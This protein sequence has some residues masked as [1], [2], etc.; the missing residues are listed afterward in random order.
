M[1]TV[2]HGG[3]S[4][5]TRLTSVQKTPDESRRSW[6]WSC[7]RNLNSRLSYTSPWPEKARTA[8]FSGASSPLTRSRKAA[9]A[10]LILLSVAFSST[11]GRIEGIDASEQRPGHPLELRRQRL[12]VLAARL[13][14]RHAGLVPVLADADGHEM[15]VDV[16]RV[17]PVEKFHLIRPARRVGDHHDHLLVLRTLE[18]KRRGAQ[19]SFWTA[20]HDG[21]ATVFASVFR[22]AGRRIW[23]PP[24][25]SSCTTEARPAPA[26]SGRAVS[27]PAAS[28]DSSPQAPPKAAE[29][30]PTCPGS[31][32]EVPPVRAGVGPGERRVAP[33]SAAGWRGRPELPE[34]RGPP[35]PC[36]YHGPPPDGCRR[37]PGSAQ[38]Q[39]R[40]TGP[41]SGWGSAGTR[42]VCP[43][44]ATTA[45]TSSSVSWCSAFGGRTRVWAWRRPVV[46]RIR[47]SS[48][49]PEPCS[50]SSSTRRPGTSRPAS[51]CRSGPPDRLRNH[52]SFSPQR[53]T[54]KW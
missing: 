25:V 34:R 29:R 43:H 9:A 11:R 53:T 15:Q 14:R 40:G 27:T 13:D 48:I 21:M 39:V 20:T 37:V 41:C 54:R 44:S 12:G 18:V 30:R 45:Q 23:T 31:A 24:A 7:G 32:D 8:S 16:V 38:V 19:M 5:R 36:R 10:V 49:R 52:Q 6:S 1:T 50:E 17:H 47:I 46:P 42:R 35:P 22:K 3:G 33:A 4:P 51:G 2:G 26:A 28:R